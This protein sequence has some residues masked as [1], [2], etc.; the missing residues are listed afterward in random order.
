MF[1][2]NLPT[3]SLTHSSKAGFFTELITNLQTI[4]K[5][6]NLFSH[7]H[8]LCN[9]NHLW[10]GTPSDV[11]IVKAYHSLIINITLLKN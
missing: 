8:F 7:I 5:L 3:L 9:V 6:K 2:K 10:R 11:T 1:L 4:P